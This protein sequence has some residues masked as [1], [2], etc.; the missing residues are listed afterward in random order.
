MALHMPVQLPQLQLEKFK[1]HASLVLKTLQKA[2]GLLLPCYFWPALL[3][4][5]KIWDMSATTVIHANRGIP[6]SLS[7][8]S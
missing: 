6:A 3:L 2:S 4:S 8:L 5:L 7:S 1:M